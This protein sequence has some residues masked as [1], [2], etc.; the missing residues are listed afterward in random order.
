[1]E[2]SRK[3]EWTGAP[4]IVPKV[5]Y[6]N[7]VPPLHFPRVPDPSAHAPRLGC[8]RLRGRPRRPGRR[9]GGRDEKPVSAGL[10]AVGA[11][12][13]GLPA[14]APAPVWLPHRRSRRR[15]PIRPPLAPVLPRPQFFKAPGEPLHGPGSGAKLV[16]RTFRRGSRYVSTI[17]RCARRVQSVSQWCSSR[18]RVTARPRLSR[19]SQAR[20][21]TSLRIGSDGATAGLRK[22]RLEPLGLTPAA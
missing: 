7:P 6:G 11:V 19:S 22:L 9:A 13:P 12:V 5:C 21:P 18:R 20:C 8:H 2:N 16:A 15:P 4:T 17:S 3:V 14:A 1:M 10:R